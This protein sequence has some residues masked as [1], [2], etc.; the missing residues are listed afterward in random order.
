MKKYIPHILIS[1]FIILQLISLNHIGNLQNELR[2]TKDQLANIASDQSREI[3]NIYSNIDTML[4]RQSSIIDSYDYS[5]GKIDSNKLTVPVT[6]NITPKEKKADTSATLYLSG[7]SMAMSKN[8]T[9]FVATL[10]VSVFDTIEAKV[11]F[12]D[13][14]IQRTE[15][16]EVVE[17]LRE[18]VLPTLYA[19]FEG[20]SGS[21]YSKKPGELSGEY[22]RKGNLSLDVKPVENNKIEKARLVIAIDGNIVSEEPINTGGLMSDIDKKIT[23]SAGE[24]L[25]M[26]VMATDSLGLI[27]E[28]VIDTMTLDKNAEPMHGDEWN[29]MGDVIITDKDGKVLYAPQYDKAD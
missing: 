23:L 3:Q 21:S 24:A 14:G 18:R 7:Q 11:V 13:S 4:K 26:S 22:Q 10:S 5:F 20:E 8:D 28:T 2:D 27:Y 29:W 6:F 19:R 17:S 9:A 25:K 15:K 1:I 16:L 12:A